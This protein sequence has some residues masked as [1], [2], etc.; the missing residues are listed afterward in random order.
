MLMNIP[1][2]SFGRSKTCWSFL[3]KPLSKHLQFFELVHGKDVSAKDLALILSKIFFLLEINQTCLLDL[4]R[5]R[6]QQ[7]SPSRLAAI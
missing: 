7:R 2:V 4:R 1:V 3:P 5:Q 6:L